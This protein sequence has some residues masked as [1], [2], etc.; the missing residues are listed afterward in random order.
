[1]ET[2]IKVSND[3]PPSPKI[4]YQGR[5]KENGDVMHGIYIRE[6][7]KTI[8]KLFINNGNLMRKYKYPRIERHFSSPMLND[9]NLHLCGGWAH[10]GVEMSE[11]LQRVID[12]K[13]PMGD[14]S[15]FSLSELEYWKGI[16]QNT[17]LPHVFYKRP[18]NSINEIGI[19]TEGTFGTIFNLPNLIHD[20]Q[21]YAKACGEPNSMLEHIREFIT[22]LKALLLHFL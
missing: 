15:T 14:Y 19:S 4:P 18:E 2:L 10:H 12:G 17:G 21:M 13:K 1:M 7:K 16:V 3:N 9:Y 8:D 5:Y 6:Y 11:S 20:Y 22:S